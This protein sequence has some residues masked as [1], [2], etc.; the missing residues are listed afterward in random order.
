MRERRWWTNRDSLLCLRKPL[1]SKIQRRHFTQKKFVWDFPAA[2]SARES[3]ATGLSRGNVTHLLCF[4][5]SSDLGNV[6]LA[7]LIFF[8]ILGIL[9]IP[10]LRF[11]NSLV[12]SYVLNSY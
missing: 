9:E 5:C 8:V 12:N 6:L 7:M 11:L 2:V 10:Q 4:L 1:K 3:Y